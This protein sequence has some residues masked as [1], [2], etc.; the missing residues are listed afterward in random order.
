MSF[1]RAPSVVFELATLILSAICSQLPSF[2]PLVCL[3][4]A[5]WRSCCLLGEAGV[6][7]HCVVIVSLAFVVFLVRVVR[8]RCGARRCLLSALSL[9]LVCFRRSRGVSVFGFSCAEC[10]PCAVSLVCVLYRS[11][12][13]R[14]GLGGAPVLRFGVFWLAASASGLSEVNLLLSRALWIPPV[15]ANDVSRFLCRWLATA[16]GSFV[17][18]RVHLRSRLRAFSI[19]RFAGSGWH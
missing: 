19:H 12:W 15:A 18:C 17:R 1:D 6:V 11:G 10:P 7:P 8:L 13:F 14:C 3:F 2:V 4:L 9:A 16:A 5:C